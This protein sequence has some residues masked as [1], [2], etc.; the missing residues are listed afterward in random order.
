MLMEVKVE[1]VD[2][3]EATIWNVVLYSL[4]WSIATVACSTFNRQVHDVMD[5][6]GIASIRPE[7]ENKG[8]VTSVVTIYSQSTLSITAQN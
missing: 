5:M 2:T 4:H 3:R 7:A 6:I 1:E 8:I